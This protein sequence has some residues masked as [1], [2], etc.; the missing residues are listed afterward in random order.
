[1]TKKE[2]KKLPKSTKFNK[3]RKRAIEIVKEDPTLSDYSVNQVLIEEGLTKQPN[4]LYQRLP[5]RELIRRDLNQVRE[6]H[7]QQLAYDMV[8][9]AFDNI[10]KVFKNK[11]LEDEKKF[12]YT[13]LVFDKY[14][15]EKERSYGPQQVN[16]GQIQAIIMQSMGEIPQDV[17]VEGE[18]VDSDDSQS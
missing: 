8:P 4:Y 11:D 18:T 6:A 10:K 17:V 1:M 15:G 12:P 9:K 2:A 16:I 13:K 3:I 7:E 14:F 5:H